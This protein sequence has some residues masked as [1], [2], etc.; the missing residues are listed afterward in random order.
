M[1]H[2]KPPAHDSRRSR[3]A[4][5]SPSCSAEVDAVADELGGVAH[6]RVNV[7]RRD[8]HPLGARVIR[9]AARVDDRRQ[10]MAATGTPSVV[11]SSPG[12]VVADTAAGA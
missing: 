7:A 10:P 11:R 12:A 4:T 3:S 9:E 1:F 2:V 5:V 6:D 8:E